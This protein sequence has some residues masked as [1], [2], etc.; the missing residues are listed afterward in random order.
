VEDLITPN[1]EYGKIGRLLALLEMVNPPP[2]RDSSIN[3]DV[4]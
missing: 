1:H 3:Q 2:N 4:E